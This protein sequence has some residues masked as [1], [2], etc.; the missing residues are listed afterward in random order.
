V[1]GPRERTEFANKKNIPK[2]L[3]FCKKWLQLSAA[4]QL[5]PFLNDRKKPQKLKKNKNICQ[6]LN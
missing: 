1:F 3:E 4:G 5:S 2:P 6:K